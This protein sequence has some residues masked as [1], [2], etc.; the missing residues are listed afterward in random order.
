MSAA[1]RTR[2]VAGD[3]IDRRSSFAG[4]SFDAFSGSRRRPAATATLLLI[5]CLCWCIRGCAHVHILHQELPSV[6]YRRAGQPNI[7][8]VENSGFCITR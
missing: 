4:F 6:R 2:T 5:L 8:G 7:T 1:A 3:L